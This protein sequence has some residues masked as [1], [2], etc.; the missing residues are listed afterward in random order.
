M[1][2][3]QSPHAADAAMFAAWTSRMCHAPVLVVDDEPGIRDILGRW[4][5]LRGYTVRTASSADEALAMMTQQSVAVALCDIRLPGHDGLWLLERIRQEFPDTAVVMVTAL[6]EV[7]PAIRSLRQGV[8]DYLTKPFSPDRLAEAVRRAMDW[9]L[10]LTDE[11]RWTERL[12]RETRDREAR[13][14]AACHGLVI[15]SDETVDALLSVL[16]LHDPVAYA[17]ARRV[18]SLAVLLC[19]R[20][21][22]PD[23]EKRVIRRAAL[24][25]DVGKTAIP[26]AVMLKP[27]P[28]TGEEYAL[29]RTHPDRAH[30]LLSGIPFLA[31]AADIVRAVHERPDGNGFPDGITDSPLGARIIAIANAYD[32][33][34]NVLTY[35]DAMPPGAALLELQ[36]G[37]GVQ[38]DP[39]LVPL[40]VALL[41][42]ASARN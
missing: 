27:A 41:G 28:L 4:L 3:E 25:H 8:V 31:E 12:E 24:L 7:G 19:D 11:R 38:F 10:S 35:R 22:R 6:Q 18:S 14:M 21:G 17:H 26:D 32:A 23:V 15:D 37:A 2:S 39:V 34:T 16:T 36:R 33:M 1:S 30:R 5:K 9:H 42:T 20:L 13:L 29:V 40:F